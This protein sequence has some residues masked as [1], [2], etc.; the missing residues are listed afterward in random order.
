MN[1]VTLSGTEIAYMDEGN[2][3]PIVLVH[4]FASNARTNWLGPGWVSTLNQAGFRVIALDNRGHG[5]SK[6]FY[7][8]EDYTLDAM[9]SDVGGLIDHLELQKPHIM[10]YSMGCRIS[11]TL[12]KSRGADLNKIILA[13]NGYNMIVGGFDTD[14]VK[15]ALLADSLEETVPGTGRDFR[16]FAEKTGNDLKALAA[17]IKGRNLDEETFRNLT[18]PTLVIIGEEDDVAVDG[19][20]LAAI[21]PNGRYESIP[22]RN[23]M[24]AVGDKIYKQKV[25]EFLTT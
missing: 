11:A 14:E 9:A 10:G 16:V 21:I 17:C 4:G 5:S 1:S 3:D 13:G 25:L 24:N 15:N 2:G 22:N 19:E 12:A 23:H 18:N 8:E 7:N 20:K 6:K